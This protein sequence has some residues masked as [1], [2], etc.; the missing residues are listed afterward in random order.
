MNEVKYL[1]IISILTMITLVTGYFG[2]QFLV[3]NNFDYRVAEAVDSV[4][5]V[6]TQYVTDKNDREKIAEKLKE[7][8]AILEKYRLKKCSR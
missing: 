8:R 6:T 4:M 5:S 1:L 7:I 2:Y 3:K